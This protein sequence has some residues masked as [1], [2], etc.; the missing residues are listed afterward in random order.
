MAAARASSSR[1]AGRDG[2]PHPCRF[3]G[4]AAEWQAFETSCSG[5]LFFQSAGWVRTVFD[6]EAERGNADFDR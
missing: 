5:A 3:R 6:F 2:A 4:V 1:L